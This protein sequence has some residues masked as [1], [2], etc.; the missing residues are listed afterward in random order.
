MQRK[1]LTDS[2]TSIIKFQILINAF[3]KTGTRYYIF[4]TQTL[5][6]KNKTRT[7]KSK[8]VIPI[9]KPPPPSPQK[10]SG[11]RFHNPDFQLFADAFLKS[12]KRD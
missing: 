10:E 6:W 4:T 8:R 3:G 1:N 2:C 7:V 9:P 11:L 5:M 12:K